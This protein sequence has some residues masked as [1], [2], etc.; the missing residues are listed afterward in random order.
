MH[1]RLNR[2]TVTIFSLSFLKPTIKVMAIVS[3]CSMLAGLSFAATTPPSGTLSPAN[4]VINYAGGPF[5]VSNASSPLGDT[6]PACAADATCSEFALTIDIPV[7]DFNSYN[8]RLHVA[9]TNQGRTTLG[10]ANS[11]YDVYVYS[12]NITGTQTGRAASSGNPEETT[13][14]VTNG[15][16]T[17]Y[18][19]PFYMSPSF[20]FT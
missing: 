14:G 6:P 17:V 11:D 13:F 20:S 10:F 1:Q 12:P 15:R 4:P 18:V 3:I 16:Y 8:V 7:T 19:V 9:W 5:A 2:S